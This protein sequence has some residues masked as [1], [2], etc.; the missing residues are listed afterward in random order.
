[1]NKNETTEKIKQIISV[2]SVKISA[3]SVVKK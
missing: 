1:M 3:P 2:A